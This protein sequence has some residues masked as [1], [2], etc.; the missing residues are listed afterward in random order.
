[1]IYGKNIVNNEV[2]NIDSD[3]EKD[4]NGYAYKYINIVN[5]E[6]SLLNDVSEL[7][8]DL[9][10]SIDV[11]TSNDI[12]Q[13]KLKGFKSHIVKLINRF[14]LY[15]KEDTKKKDTKNN[16]KPDIKN[17]TKNYTKP[18]TNDDTKVFIEN[19]NQ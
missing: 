18:D 12:A 9:M 17:N 3:K 1:M 14:N 11:N 6:I 15:I 8:G 2:N 7:I 13:E 5:D 4:A 16:T 10:G 19:K